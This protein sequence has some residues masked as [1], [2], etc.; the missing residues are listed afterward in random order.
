VWAKHGVTSR[1][2]IS[3]KRAAG[4]VKYAEIAANNEYHNLLVGEIATG[5][6]PEEIRAI[7]QTFNIQQEIYEPKDIIM[8][9]LLADDHLLFIEGVTNLLKAYGMEET[10]FHPSRLVLRSGCWRNLPVCLQRRLP[11]IT[12]LTSWKITSRIS[13]KIS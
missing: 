2:D 13:A 5:L 11:K 6:I 4:R 9:L 1:S 7:C 8:R 3:A 12:H 10:A